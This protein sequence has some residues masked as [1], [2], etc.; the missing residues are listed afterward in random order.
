MGG[1]FGGIDT[2]FAVSQD[3]PNIIVGADG[4]YD[5]YVNPD[6]GIAWITAA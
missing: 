2:E 3:G 1:D 4:V 5:L 6:Q